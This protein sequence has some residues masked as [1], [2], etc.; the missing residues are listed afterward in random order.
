GHP[1]NLE[2]LLIRVIDTTRQ[3]SYIAPDAVHIFDFTQWRQDAETYLK[4]VAGELREL[5]YRVHITVGDGDVATTIC[6]VAK[7]QDADLIAMTTHGRSGVQ[8]W[9]M[10]SVAERVIRTAQQPVYLIRPG[11]DV[12]SSGA[13]QPLLIPLDGSLLA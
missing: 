7:A 4:R 1:D 12:V 9:I 2:L 10:G 8:R 11:K 5:G 6:Q 3:Y 13:P